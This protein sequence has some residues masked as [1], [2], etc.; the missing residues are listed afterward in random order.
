MLA[1]V[2]ARKCGATIFFLRY[3]RK[4]GLVFSEDKRI[5]TWCIIFQG[6][7]M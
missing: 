6:P 7:V 1:V 5:D 2:E 4:R 3:R